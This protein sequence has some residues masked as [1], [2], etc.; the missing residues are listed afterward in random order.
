MRYFY[1]SVTGFLL[2]VAGLGITILPAP[3][4]ASISEEVFSDWF[5]YQFILA[6]VIGGVSGLLAASRSMKR[7][8]IEPADDANSFGRRV[9]LK[10]LWSGVGAVTLMLAVLVVLAAYH[11]AFNPASPIERVI[12]V[13]TSGKMLGVLA[14][15]G[16]VCLA[17]YAGRGRASRWGG[18]FALI[19][20]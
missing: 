20:Q 14:T 4:H 3:E 5:L 19:P 16:F 6:I 10:G 7:T 8:R 11:S 1:W 18:T 15:A 9:M 17:V 2:L 12:L 13:A